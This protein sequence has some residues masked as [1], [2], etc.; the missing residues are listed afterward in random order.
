[1]DSLSISLPL[2]ARA[3]CRALL[4]LSR[5]L[6]CFY[7]PVSRA[8]PL[9]FSTSFSTSALSLSASTPPFRARYKSISSS[10]PPSFPFS[11]FPLFLRSQQDSI[12]SLN[13]VNRS[14]FRVPA[15][16]RIIRRHFSSILP[17]LVLLLLLLLLH[18]HHQQ[19]EKQDAERTETRRHCSCF[20]YCSEPWKQ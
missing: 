6:L 20:Y 15:F 12:N 2:A 17:L 4:S 5:T 18:H 7:S 13:R 14:R 10:L 9:L 1:M 11:T 19:A 8:L 3:R 16:Q